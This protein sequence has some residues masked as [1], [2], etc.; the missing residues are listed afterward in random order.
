MK[1]LEA[2]RA[3]LKNCQQRLTMMSVEKK[4][5]QTQLAEMKDRLAKLMNEKSLVKNGIVINNLPRSYLQ[6]FSNLT[7]IANKDSIIDAE[8]PEILSQKDEVLQENLSLRS[9][10][11]EV[12][13]SLD[14]LQKLVFKKN[15]EDEEALNSLTDGQFELPLS[16]VNEEL[17]NSFKE[18]IAGLQSRI[19]ALNENEKLSNEEHRQQAEEVIQQQQEMLQFLISQK[20]DN[21]TAPFERL[22]K[23]HVDLLEKES[24]KLAKAEQS[25]YSLP[26]SIG[27]FAAGG[28]MTFE[29]ENSSQPLSGKNI[30][31]SMGTSLLPTTMPSVIPPSSLNNSKLLI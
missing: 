11:K 17:K 16:I 2:I 1:D 3:N 10:L 31:I 28:N 5:L 20:A 29:K 23:E 6:N 9:S 12:N 8:F 27:D 24:M 21:I 19:A 25:L 4:Q 7:S 26:T 14:E 30:E 22:L 18:K 15:Y 13:Q